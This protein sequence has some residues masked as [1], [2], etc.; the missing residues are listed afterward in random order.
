[1][2]HTVGHITGYY[3]GQRDTITTAHHATWRTLQIGLVAAVPKG[4]NFPSVNG[5]LTIGQVWDDNKIDEICTIEAL[6]EAAQNSEIKRT[7]SPADEVASLATHDPKKPRQTKAKERFL[8]TRPD[9]IAHHN[10]K[11]IWYLL[12]FKR[13]SDVRPDY[14]ETKKDMQYT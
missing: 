1:M 3:L 11:K 6:W 2:V 7:L 9:G 13:T 14:F 10:E 12:E 4:W 5:E 8:R